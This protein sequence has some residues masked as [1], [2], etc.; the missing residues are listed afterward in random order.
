MVFHNDNIL[1]AN[2]IPFKNFNILLDKII[3]FSYFTCYFVIKYVRM[4]E[5]TATIITKFM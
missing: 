4:I 3:K 1:T 2:N 5:K